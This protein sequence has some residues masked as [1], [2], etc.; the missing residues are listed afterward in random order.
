MPRDQGGQQGGGL[1]EGKVGGRVLKCTGKGSPRASGRE[2][3]RGGTVDRRSWA[4][5][6]HV[7]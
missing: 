4:R 1:G 3:R 2:T 6:V 5:Q 7:C